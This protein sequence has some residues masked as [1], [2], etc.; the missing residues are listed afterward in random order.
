MTY[1]NEKSKQVEYKEFA[2]VFKAG[3][4]LTALKE[5]L[6]KKIPDT[7]PAGCKLEVELYFRLIKELKSI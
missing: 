7:V 1:W 5:G 3:D 4:S 2:K 6:Q